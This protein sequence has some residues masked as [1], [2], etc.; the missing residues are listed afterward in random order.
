MMFG[1]TVI[2]EEDKR[3]SI[4]EIIMVESGN[5]V[6][7]EGINNMKEK[8]VMLKANCLKLDPTLE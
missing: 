2:K 6:L 4:E 8:I 7:L 1:Y 5:K 3:K